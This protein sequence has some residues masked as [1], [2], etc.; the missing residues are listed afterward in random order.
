M[1]AAAVARWTAQAQFGGPGS[2]DPGERAGAGLAGRERR[3]A[4]P[5]GS[6]GPEDPETPVM[7]RV[8]ARV[9]ARIGAESTGSSRSG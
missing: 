6:Q 9:K 8:K 3:I 5:G 2:A 4:G 1:R 7:A